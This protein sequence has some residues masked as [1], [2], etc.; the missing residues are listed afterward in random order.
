[1]GGDVALP[2][3]LRKLWPKSF[4]L[5]LTEQTI[6]ESYHNNGRLS[7]RCY[8]NNAKRDADIGVQEITYQEVWLPIPRFSHRQDVI[9]Q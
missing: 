7:Y 8:G 3:A 9:T 1:M 5:S 4:S 6:E 2:E